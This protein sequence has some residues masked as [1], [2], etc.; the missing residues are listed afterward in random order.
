[1]KK[2][3][4]KKGRAISGILVLN[5]PLGITSNKALQKVKWLLGAAKA[6]HTGALD[7][8][9]SGV[10]PLCFGDATKFSQVLLESTKGYITTAKLGEVRSTGDQEGE[11][12]KTRTVP[13]FDAASVEIIL[14]RFRGNITQV[15]PMY[16]ALKHEGRPLYELA[17]KGIEL[18]LKA[19]KQRQV[20]IHSLKLLAIRP[21]TGEIDLEVICAKGTYIRSLV[22][23]IGEAI[24]CGAYVSMLHRIQAGPFNEADMVEWDDVLASESI[25]DLAQRHEI[26]D[27]QL[28][29]PAT[30]IPDWPR[31]D[32]TL[33]QGQQILHGQRLNTGL[34]AASQV[35]LWVDTDLDSVFVGIGEVLADG[36]VVPKKVLQVSL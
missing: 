33:A 24:G 36:T 8:M 4:V 29:H 14:Q 32:L 6:G 26:L 27:R 2:N 22:E 9:A 3:R 11:V 31:V 5:K 34:K 13:E 15:P 30:A 7:P 10:L 17:R 19:L 1:M 21:E 35:Q 18:D 23:D 28:K 20:V 16:S 12:V 25:E